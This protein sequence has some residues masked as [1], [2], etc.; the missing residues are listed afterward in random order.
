MKLSTALLALTLVG[1]VPARAGTI[2]ITYTYSGVGTV[3]GMNGVFLDLSGAATGSV[4]EWNPSVNAIWNPVTYDDMGQ[5]NLSTGLF[6]GTFTIMF[7]NG[8]TLSGTA[9]ENQTMVN[10]M[11]ASGPFTQTLTFTAGT[12]EFA[13]VSGTGSG[14]GSVTPT[15]YTDSGSGTLTASGLVAPEPGSITLVFG[16]LLL[17]ALRYRSQP[18][19]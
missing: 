12:G 15:G 17:I 5:L 13:G 4:D 19:N 1:S 16:G 7:A 9:F 6:N 18:A 2:G 10:P 14:G 11:T 3:T 8:D